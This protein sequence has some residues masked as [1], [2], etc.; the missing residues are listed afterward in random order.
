MPPQHRPPALRPLNLRHGDAQQIA[1]H[2]ERA[3]RPLVPWQRA[4]LDRIESASIAEQF[5][6]IIRAMR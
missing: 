4:L 5:E 2:C 1:D 3:G 6:Q